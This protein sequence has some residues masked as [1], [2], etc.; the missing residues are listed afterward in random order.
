[1]CSVAGEEDRDADKASR[2][3]GR[4]RLAR[5]RPVDKPKVTGAADRRR[6]PRQ[7]AIV[8][9]LKEVWSDLVC[10]VVLCCIFANWYLVRPDRCSNF[11]ESCPGVTDVETVG[12]Q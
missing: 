3:I 8:A 5:K 12:S 7:S 1:M 9:I 10:C 11:L 4:W 2:R 6:A